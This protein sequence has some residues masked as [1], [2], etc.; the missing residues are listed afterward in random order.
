MKGNKR[1][2]GIYIH[3]PFCL[4]KCSYC[5]FY[6]ETFYTEEFLD[7]YVKALLKEI[8]KVEVKEDLEFI[9][10]YIGG[11]TPSL[12]KGGQVELLLQKVKD[13]FALKDDVEITL[14]ANPATLT[15]SRIS[16]FY[17]AG[18]NRFSL[19]AQSFVDNELEV[20]Y[21]MHREKDI[22]E[23]VE[24]LNRL[25]IKNYNLDL[26]YGI[27]GQTAE[28]WGYSLRKAADCG[29]VH[30]SA[31]LLQLDDMVP[32][33]EAIRKGFLSLLSDEEEHDLYYQ[34]VGYLETR[35][36]KQYEISNFCREGWACRHNLLYWQANEYIGLGAGAVSFLEGR[37]FMN[38]DL[39]A[40]YIENL[41]RDRRPEIKELEFMAT[42]EEK[43]IDAIV[44]GLRLCQGINIEEFKDRFGIDIEEKYQNIIRKY[45]REK[46]LE[47]KD[48]YMRLT[49]KGY[50]LSNEVLRGFIIS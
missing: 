2:A 13:R 3:I 9:S 49:K 1:E 48:G 8:E 22:L 39:A 44:L 41:E 17:E 38:A 36:F 16:H 6:S 21:R 40:G 15:E 47:L 30:I 28:S 27:P 4:R 26:I 32:M 35:G 20:L 42:G 25:G 24:S 11:G 43:A 23:V 37:R 5:D 33:A 14:E 46:L 19:G 12:L 31:Y 18:V 10:V 34:A 7:R 50:F 45:E 29:P